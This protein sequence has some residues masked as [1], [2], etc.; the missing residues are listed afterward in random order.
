M[1]S[2]FLPSRVQC[3]AMERTTWPTEHVE[4]DVNAPA[5]VFAVSRVEMRMQRAEPDL[6]RR[7]L[8]ASGRDRVVTLLRNPEARARVAA[9]A[10]HDSVIHCN[11]VSEVATALTKERATILVIAIDKY[12]QYS[13]AD[14]VG[15]LREHFPAVSTIAYCSTVQ[16][17]STTIL[18]IVRAG[19]HGLIFHGIDDDVVSLRDVIESAR[20]SGVRQRV[21]CAL[22]PM[23]SPKLRQ[24][25]SY[26]LAH[27]NT[28][29]SVTRA[30]RYLGI[31]RKTLFNWCSSQRLSGPREFM[32]WIRLAVGVAL[33]ASSHITVESVAMDLGF[34]SGAG[35][36]NM[37]QRYAGLTVVQARSLDGFER[38]IRSLQSRLAVTPLAFSSGGSTPLGA[39][40]GGDIHP[41]Q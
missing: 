28:P 12:G 2:E 29:P 22:I 30:A 4:V 18:P 32:N 9:A 19:V 26:A 14:I 36:R 31:D 33:L 7:N 38:V 21:E 23:L 6:L 5:F 10:G 16:S 3:Q 8:L 17:S 24:L 34:S 25:L 13:T 11:G 15:W 39:V 35:F 20:G 41:I 27:V 37:L 40:V 1:H